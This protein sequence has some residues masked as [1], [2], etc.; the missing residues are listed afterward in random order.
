LGFCFGILP[1]SILH[2]NQSVWALHYSP[3]PFS[4][5]CIGHFQCVSC[6]ACSELQAQSCAHANPKHFIADHVTAGRPR[7]IV[8]LSQL[9]LSLYPQWVFH[10]FLLCG[11]WGSPVTLSKC[12]SLCASAVWELITPGLWTTCGVGAGTVSCIPLLQ[13]KRLHLFYCQLQRSYSVRDVR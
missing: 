8:P 6:A 7:E 12:L 11:F 5:P 1:V 4:L 10:D 3:S 9:F 2:F 13:E